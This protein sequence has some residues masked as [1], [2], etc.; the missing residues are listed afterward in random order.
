MREGD[1]VE[2]FYDPDHPDTVYLPGVQ[3]WT[4]NAA[5]LFI[6]GCWLLGGVML[7]I[8]GILGVK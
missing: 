7:F 4:A 8:C 3:T 2:I 6:G 1:A 5:L